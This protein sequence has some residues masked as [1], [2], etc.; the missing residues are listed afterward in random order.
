MTAL[1]FDHQSQTSGRHYRLT[2]VLNTRNATGKAEVDEGVKESRLKGLKDRL[3]A[4]DGE[5]AE[6]LR[7]EIEELES[8]IDELTSFRTGAEVQ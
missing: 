4:T 8:R 7:S 3:A 5:E 1:T 6:A 2:P